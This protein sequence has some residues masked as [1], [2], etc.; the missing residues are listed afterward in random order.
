LR[1]GDVPLRAEVAGYVDLQTM[2]SD[3]AIFQIFLT[4]ILCVRKLPTVYLCIIRS[5]SKVTVGKVCNSAVG[6]LALV[7]VGSWKRLNQSLR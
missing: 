5:L 2:S 1:E 7:D 3:L 6:H 4:L